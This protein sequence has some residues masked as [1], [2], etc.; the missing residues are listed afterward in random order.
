MKAKLSEVK[1]QNIEKQITHIKEYQ[2]FLKQ[3][4]R[5]H[6][7]KVKGLSKESQRQFTKMQGLYARLRSK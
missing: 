2:Q 1:K 5:F 4:I 3:E 6:E 7:K